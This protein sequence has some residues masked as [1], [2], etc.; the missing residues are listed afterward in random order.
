MSQ[1]FRELANII[2]KF[3]AQNL[4]I[5]DAPEI[6]PRG[7]SARRVTVPPEGSTLVKQMELVTKHTQP[8]SST[9]QRMTLPSL[10]VD[11][12][13][14][15]PLK[16]LIRPTSIS[17]NVDHNLYR[18]NDTVT[19]TG[20]ILLEAMNIDTLLTS[21]VDPTAYTFNQ[22]IVGSESLELV[23]TVEARQP[24]AQISTS[25]TSTTPTLT[26]F[27]QSSGYTT[28]TDAIDY[29][30]FRM[31]TTIQPVIGDFDAFILRRGSLAPAD[32]VFQTLTNEEIKFSEME[33][34]LDV[35][36]N[37]LEDYLVSPDTH[38]IVKAFSTKDV[39]F[40]P[41]QRI[42]EGTTVSLVYEAST[43]GGR[44]PPYNPNTAY[45]SAVDLS[46]VSSSTRHM[47]IYAYGAYPYFHIPLSRGF[48]IEYPLDVLDGYILPAG[49]ILQESTTFND[50]LS[51]YTPLTLSNVVA[52]PGS[53]FPVGTIIAHGVPFSHDV[54]VPKGFSSSYEQLLPLGAHVEEP[55]RIAGVTIPEGN[56]LPSELTTSSMLELTE[57]ITAG[58]GTLLKKGTSIPKGALTSEG[59]LIQDSINFEAGTVL[60]YDINIKTPFVVE[61]GRTL[62]PGTK[63][64]APFILPQGTVISN[65]N[66]LPAPVKILMSMGVTLNAGMELEAGT[67]LG[68]GATLYGDIGFAKNGYIPAG[69]ILSGT[70]NFPIGSTLQKGTSIP[71]TVP[72]PLNTL[73]PKDSIFP[74]GTVFNDG[75][76]MPFISNI[77]EQIAVHATGLNGP[78]TRIDET[79]ISYIN[80]KGGSSLTSGFVLPK[81]S[82]LSKN[83]TPGNTH[84]VTEAGIGT[85][86]NYILDA[87]EFSFDQHIRSAA[88]QDY[89]I[90]AGTPLANNIVLLVDIMFDT[91]VLIPFDKIGEN[92]LEEIVFNEPFT[93]LNDLKLVE[94]FTVHVTN[95][96]M[97]PP[98]ALLPADYTFTGQHTFTYTHLILNKRL[99]FNFNTTDDFTYGFVNGA[100]SSIKF[101]SP[102]HRLET[103]IKLAVAQPVANTGTYS[104]KAFVELAK[105]TVLDVSTSGT[106]VPFLSLTTQLP[107]EVNDD[108]LIGASM[109]APRI[110]LPNGIS[111]R[112]GA[113]TPGD[114]SFSGNTGLPK[115][116]TLPIAIVL[117]ADH[118]VTEDT[119]GLPVYTK[120]AAG[121]VLARET[122][123]PTGFFFS[124]PVT[125][126]PFLSLDTDSRFYV[127]E[128]DFFRTDV[129]Y[130]YL[131]EPSTDLMTIFHTDSRNLVL[132]IEV[133]KEL[134]KALEL[135]V[136]GM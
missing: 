31:V 113:T 68:G 87:G 52:H 1:P 44:T 48:K 16:L 94:D 101:P 82:I 110:S 97:F 83:Q 9:H 95:S 67:V 98:N 36:N 43:A 85:G 28:F 60:S 24:G 118:V 122:S 46:T 99:Q 93:L 11:E 32:D 7:F 131:V 61:S 72:L 123:F 3:D 55:L 129:L 37:F 25:L 59:A 27:I 81:G 80:I 23:G 133:L 77:A 108:F 53:V 111:L 33:E 78:L 69:S 20:A 79:G 64:R 50:L 90:I 56:K 18:R 96:V 54:R 66:H 2:F 13:S 126:S 114:F 5:A 17:A 29:G 15:E 115:N 42:P 135:Q 89:T 49:H 128:S 107:I 84:T 127:N 116:M 105:G 88:G 132:E 130:P 51:G 92:F 47:L 75:A 63:L 119:Y 103:P 41:R 62:T 102:N 71:I 70:F 136:G 86:A 8:H 6:A 121:S 106:G 76:S 35:N 34:M 100:T 65:G 117:A 73:V 19:G 30:L 40:L 4:T 38:Q 124:D 14:P 57:V 10:L 45:T 12:N 91:D 104:T 120:L 112:A 125:L 39:T 74:K 22:A 58:K 134:T 21:D 109:T 26:D